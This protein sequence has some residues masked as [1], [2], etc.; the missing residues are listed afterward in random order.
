MKKLL[1]LV[2]V[3]IAL[4]TRAQQTTMYNQYTFNKAGMNPAASGSDINQIYY[5]AGG[6]NKQWV[7]M[8]NAPRQYFFNYSYTI[9]PPRS[10]RQWQNI[11]FYTD[12]DESGLM[13][14]SGVYLGY[15]YHMLLKKKTVMS[16]GVYAGAKK[17]IRSIGY[18]DIN[19]PAVQKNKTALYLYPDIIPGFRISD[20][21]YFLGVSIRQLSITKLQDFKG[22]KI[23]S[24]SK[25]QPSIYFDYG[26][27]ITITDHL[28][29][30]PS[31]ALNL[32]I[33]APPIVDLNVMFYY[34]HRIGGGV[35]IRNASF[36]SATF[37]IRFLGNMT[38]GFAY[39]YPINQTRFGAG[40]SYELMIGLVP[41]GMASSITSKLSVARCPGLNY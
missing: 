23:G 26:K 9:R 31:M 19:D 28:L 33:I 41:L 38:A 11:S 17:Y 16:F 35:G 25:L 6:L 21:N 2:F 27:F 10:Y 36:V 37:Q 20:K 29:M 1:I 14:N 39:S 15:T 34:L 8:D 5:F 13:V 7:G 32:P 3:L 40:N 22:R 12:N 18:F 4:Y 30:M 24:P